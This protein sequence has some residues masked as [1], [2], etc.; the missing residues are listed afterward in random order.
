M[1]TNALI[2]EKVDQARD[3]LKEFGVD[4]WITFARETQIN[5][6]PTLAFLVGGDLTWHSALILTAKG[7]PS[8]SL[9]STTRKW[10][11]TLVHTRR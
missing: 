8:Q 4:C 1:N 2:Q 3:I 9:G 6:D 11:R 7:M 5:G 10:W